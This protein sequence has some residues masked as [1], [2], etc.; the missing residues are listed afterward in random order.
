M[1]R[2]LT[3]AFTL[4]C[5]TGSSLSFA[6][7]TYESGDS[8][9]KVGGRIQLQY[10]LTMPDEGKD[11][12]ELFFR[13]LR[14]YIEGSIHKDWKG[15]FQWDMGKNTI[16]IKDAYME[17]NGLDFMEVIIGNHLFPFSREGL[18]SSKKQQLVEKTFVGDHNYGTPDVQ[19][20]VHFKG[21]AMD[22]KIAWGA[23]FCKGAIDPDN[24]KLDFDTVVQYDA[25]ED[26]SEGDMFGVRLDFHPLGQ[27]KLAQGDFKRKFKAAVGV[28]GFSWT[29]D[30]DNI[31]ES[32]SKKDVDNV[33]GIE[34]S[35][36]I[37]GLGFSLDA[38]Y[39]LFISEL[40]ESGITSGLYKNS[41]T[42]L[43]N[44]AIEAGY[45][46]LPG[47]F[48]I[49]TAYESQDADNYTKEWTRISG[50][51]NYFIAKH[52]IKIQATYRVGENLKGQK[53]NDE[54]ELFVQMQYVF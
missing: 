47:K 24:N 54:D 31:D 32:R 1:K 27:M 46:I 37:R 25:G 9:F 38:Q 22:K 13:R 19:T 35:S 39:N 3:I 2:T 4:L 8:F 53:N 52:D 48:E 34:I 33:T 44:M 26:W 21:N 10:H 17:Y 28:A 16:A 36:A 41:K 7:V 50:G 12:D 42:D 6:G 23:S 29:N 49:V 18:S 20:G 45:M 51:L 5:L 43:S 30:K 11:T 15:K 14:P 40:V